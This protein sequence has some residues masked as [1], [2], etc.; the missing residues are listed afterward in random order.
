MRM[1]ALEIVSLAVAF[2]KALDQAF[3]EVP[4]E[5]RLEATRRALLHQGFSEETVWKGALPGAI[6]GVARSDR[7][8]SP[9]LLA[10]YGSIVLEVGEGY[11]SPPNR[12]PKGVWERRSLTT[13]L[14]LPPYRGGVQIALPASVWEGIEKALALLAEEVGVTPPPPFPKASTRLYHSPLLVGDILLLQFEVQK[15]EKTKMILVSGAGGTLLLELFPKEDPLERRERKREALKLFDEVLFKASHGNPAFF[16]EEELAKLLETDDFSGGLAIE[17][18]RH[19]KV[20][21]FLSL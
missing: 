6:Y 15:A 17:G 1:R 18:L 19:P 14:V 3:S 16:P 20:F 10:R 9:V 5:E 4:F 21:P 11:I 12:I 8:G 7:Y 2:D 13:P